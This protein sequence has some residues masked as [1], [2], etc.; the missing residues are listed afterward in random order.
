MRWLPLDLM[1]A[2]LVVTWAG[3]WRH[4]IHRVPFL[5]G[6]TPDS[7]LPMLGLGALLYV[8]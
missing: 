7:S 6:L 3:L 2:A 4:D 1:D 5:L 8:G